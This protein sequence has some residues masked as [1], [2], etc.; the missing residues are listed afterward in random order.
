[1]DNNVHSI[2]EFINEEDFTVYGGE[3]SSPFDSECGNLRKCG[4]N[5]VKCPKLEGCTWNFFGIDGSV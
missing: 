1:M 4:W 2:I 3:N 5:T